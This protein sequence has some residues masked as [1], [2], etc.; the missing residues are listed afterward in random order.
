MEEHQQPFHSK[1]TEWLYL[2]SLV[3]V[4][5]F[6]FCSM[7]SCNLVAAATNGT[8]GVHTQPATNLVPLRLQL[9]APAIGSGPE[10]LPKGPHIEPLSDRP[11]APF[12][13]PVGLTNV[14]L[15]KP[16]T[17]S[18]EKPL[19]GSLGMVT[20]GKK[21]AFDFDRMELP[22]G[23]QWVRIDLGRLYSIHAIIVWH[24][25][26]WGYPLFNCVIVQVADDAEFKSNVRTLFNNDYENVA[27]MG[28]GT[29]KQYFETHEGK[30]IDAKGTK[31]RYL[32]FYSNGSTN[33]KR[34]GYTEV[35]VWALRSD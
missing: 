2:Q 26:R 3:V 14:A 35:E 13:V 22:K 34:N 11:R 5:A 12:F 30:L 10:D 1:L 28:A 21:E 27:G 18:A 7:P 4:A 25:H 17:A 31:A 20:D 32:R 23:L 19:H 29:D 16:V 15:G 6:W 9:P 24:D 8:A 33:S